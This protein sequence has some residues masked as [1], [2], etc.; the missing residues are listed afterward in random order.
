MLN[1]AALLLAGRFV[2][3]FL[4]AAVAVAAGAAVLER[5]W[6][7]GALAALAA[8]AALSLSAV[9]M[10]TQAS[11]LADLPDAF[12]VAE[13]AAALRVTV[14]LLLMHSHAGAAW[15]SGMAA[16]LAAAGSL[17]LGWR[18]IGL[19][20]LAGFLLSRALV[21]H[22]AGGGDLSLAVLLQWL[23]LCGACVWAGVV[24]AGAMLSAGMIGQYAQRLSRVATVALCVVL[25]SAVLRLLMMA[26]EVEVSRAYLTAL[27]VKIALVAAAAGLG[28]YNRFMRLPALRQDRAASHAFL[29]VLRIEAAVML[30]VLL[31]ATVL[32]S[33][34]PV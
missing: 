25:A 7:A 4:Y 19:I 1:A 2:A 27:A 29:R 34:S 15:W 26:A 16:L 3:A 31:A 18:R 32:G 17:R 8:L 24:L 5:R 30:A 20:A 28:A 11:L 23:H 22:A 12:S 21:S 9:A 6:P 14:P 13:L 33:T 10:L